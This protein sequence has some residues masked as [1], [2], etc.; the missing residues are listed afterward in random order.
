MLALLGREGNGRNG[1]EK[2]NKLNIGAKQTERGRDKAR[3]STRCVVFCN[4]LTGS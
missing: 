2:L 4:G 3:P 1:A